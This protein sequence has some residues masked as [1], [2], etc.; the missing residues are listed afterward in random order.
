M[1]GTRYTEFP[2]HAVRKTDFESWTSPDRTLGESLLSGIPYSRNREVSP[3]CLELNTVT[4][5]R[6]AIVPAKIIC[7]IFSVGVSRTIPEGSDFIL[8]SGMPT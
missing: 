5:N 3:G 2:T 8:E 1:K 6:D 7:R 4:A